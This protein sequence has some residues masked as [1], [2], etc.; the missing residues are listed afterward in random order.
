MQEVSC[1]PVGISCSI[2]FPPPPSPTFRCCRCK[3]WNQ[4]LTFSFIL[5]LP[6]RHGCARIPL[7]SKLCVRQY[8]VSWRT[9]KLSPQFLNHLFSTKNV[10]GISATKVNILEYQWVF[11]LVYLSV[12]HLFVQRSRTFQMNVLFCLIQFFVISVL[13]AGNRWDI[14]APKLTGVVTS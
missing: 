6:D 3:K 7:S 12:A 4:L 13:C 14:C 11:L 1:F 9:A 5:W 10:C 2:P 8:M